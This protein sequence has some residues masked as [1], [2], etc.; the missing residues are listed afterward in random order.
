MTLDQTWLLNT[1]RESERQTRLRRLAVNLLNSL[2][3][4]KYQRNLAPVLCKTKDAPSNLEA[5][6]NWLRQQHPHA[7]WADRSVLEEQLKRQL[8]IWELDRW[9]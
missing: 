3:A 1:I 2:G 9:A 4:S 8:T 5:M 6:H 7:T